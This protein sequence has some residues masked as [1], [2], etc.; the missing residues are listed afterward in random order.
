MTDFGFTPNFG[1][2]NMAYSKPI[3]PADQVSSLSE[4][5]DNES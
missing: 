2:H 3:R 4:A 5:Q 1:E